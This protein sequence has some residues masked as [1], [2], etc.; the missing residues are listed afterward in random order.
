MYIY[1]S[2]FIHSF[3]S[4]LDKQLPVFYKTN[5]FLENHLP[6]LGDFA[7][8]CKTR[9]GI[10]KTN[11]CWQP[12]FYGWSRAFLLLILKSDR[13]IKEVYNLASLMAQMV[14][15]LSA[16]QE[17]WVWSLGWENP[18]EK[19]M[20]THSSTLAW[21]I[22]WTEEPGRLQSVGSQGVR[23]DWVTNTFTVTLPLSHMLAM[24]WPNFSKPG[25][26]NT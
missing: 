4:S 15:R 16:V 3:H 5:L 18:L 22:P 26:N 19:E 12:C 10:R 20:A 23:H 7:I 8:V 14:K 17:T 13:H 24:E 6:T 2:F 1:H 11:T 9:K 21:K 25:F